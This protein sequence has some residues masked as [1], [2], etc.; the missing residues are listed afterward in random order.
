MRDM[1]DLYRLILRMEHHWQRI[2][3]TI[4]GGPEA[5]QPKPIESA[6]SVAAVRTV[7]VGPMAVIVRSGNDQDVPSQIEH[8]TVQTSEGKLRRVSRLK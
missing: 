3:D 4:C 5:E 6:A 2:A 7:G 8:D 1:D